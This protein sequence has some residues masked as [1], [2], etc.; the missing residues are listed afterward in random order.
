M[1]VL[2]GVNL[3]EFNKVYRMDNLELLKSL[4]DKSIQLI[5]C[6]ILYNT[7]KQFKDY[8]DNL[9]TPEEAIEWYRPRLKEMNRVLS[10]KGVIYLQMDHNLIT[11]IGALMDNIYGYRNFRS[12]IIWKRS[13]GHNLSKKDVVNTTDY[14]IKY[15]KTNF[16]THNP[17][18]VTL[19]EEELNEKFP[20]TE[21]ETGRR[22]N[23]EKLEKSSNAYNKNEVRVIQGREVKTDLGWIWTQKELDKRLVANPY[24][25]YWTKNG[26]PRYKN[27]ADEY[28]GKLITN[29]WDD[30]QNITSNSSESVEYF[31]QKPKELLERIILMS[32]NEGDLIADFF[33]GSGTSLVVAKE[34][35]R[36]YIGCDINPRA[37]EIA[38][39][40]LNGVTA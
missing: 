35:N 9:G 30:I 5:Y 2:R 8:D 38:N 15:S 37:I 23:T 28:E 26:K 13:S 4:N 20:Y 18:Y 17:L 31:S 21:K 40:R 32:S 27:Y 7:G 16:Y 33:L 1:R 10:D 11:R 24:V 19:A 6:D 25:I 3:L 22:F 14:I 12:Q 36:Q 39:D 29:M 34:L